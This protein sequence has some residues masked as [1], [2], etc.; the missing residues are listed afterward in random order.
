MVLYKDV[1]HVF[2]FSVFH[3]PFPFPVSSLFSVSPVVS[4]CAM[5]STWGMSAK[6]LLRVS[7]KG[8]ITPSY[9]RKPAHIIEPYAE[10]EKSSLRV[11]NSA[12]ASLLPL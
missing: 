7:G 6:L 2:L 4:Q 3:F 8:H 1:Y 10:R 11:V 5:T 12:M 9:R